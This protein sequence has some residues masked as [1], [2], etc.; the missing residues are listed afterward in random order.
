VSNGQSSK[1]DGTKGWLTVIA[2]AAHVKYSRCSMVAG[3]VYELLRARLDDSPKIDG[4]QTRETS[5]SID[6]GQS[7]A[8]I[9]D[10]LLLFMPLCRI[11]NIGDDLGILA[12]RYNHIRIGGERRRSKPDFHHVIAMQNSFPGLCLLVPHS[13]ITFR[14]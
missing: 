13:P 4:R 8:G 6:K 11:V 1:K 10:V 3:Y 12:L 9:A 5:K 7:G 2:V 14:S